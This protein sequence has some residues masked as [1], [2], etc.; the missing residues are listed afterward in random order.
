MPY[1]SH[2]HDSSIGD[3]AMRKLHLTFAIVLVFI[4]FVGVLLLTRS[5]LSARELCIAE[6][7]Q[8]AKQVQLWET[9]IAM[10]ESTDQF[11][12]R[13]A[14]EVA[15]NAANKAEFRRFLGETFNQR[16]C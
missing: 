12:N 9:V 2:H 3:E 1:S 10:S 5:V 8:A 7:K 15:I 14:E 13:T 6:N 4:L 16:A 11:K